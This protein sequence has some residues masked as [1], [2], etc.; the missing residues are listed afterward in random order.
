MEKNR[1]IYFLNTS[2][3]NIHE[4]KYFPME[5]YPILKEYIAQHYQLETT[6]DGV[7]I[8]RRLGLR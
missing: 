6:I 7:E 8:Y 3:A 2:P 5:N 4:Y 1:P